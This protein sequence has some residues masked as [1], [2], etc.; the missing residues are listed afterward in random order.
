MIPFTAWAGALGFGC[1]DSFFAGADDVCGVAGSRGRFLRF[2]LRPSRFWLR[3]GSG[4]CRVR[5]VA[6]AVAA[7]V[8]GTAEAAEAGAGGLRISAGVAGSVDLEA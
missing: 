6:G 3:Y 4:S 7:A 5:P 1:L 8:A 2:L